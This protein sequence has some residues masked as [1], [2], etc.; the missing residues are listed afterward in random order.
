MGRPPSGSTC[1]CTDPLLRPN[2][3]CPEP[4]HAIRAR[5]LAEVRALEAAD[6]PGAPERPPLTRR[7]RAQLVA[8]ARGHLARR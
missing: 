3:G 8:A 4:V 5:R 1:T 6:R 7:E 2:G